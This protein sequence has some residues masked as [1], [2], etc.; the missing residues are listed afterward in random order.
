MAIE[1]LLAINRTFVHE[2]R[3]DLES[4]LYIILYVCTFVCG[5]G[6]PLLWPQRRLETHPMSPPIRTWFCDAG[7][8]EIGYRKVAHIEHYEVAILLYFTPYWRDFAPFAK[9]LITSCFPVKPLLPNDF[10]YNKFLQ[11]LKTAY[12]SVGE[13]QPGHIPRT[14]ASKAFGAQPP[15]WTL[16]RV[17]SSSESD[18]N[19][20][21]GRYL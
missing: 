17:G 2:P 4:I 5:P 15:T 1:A 12:D 19:S 10:Q 13:P 8:G 3:H 18:R 21:K 6:L 11:I 7:I 9:E 20:K 14:L 16:K